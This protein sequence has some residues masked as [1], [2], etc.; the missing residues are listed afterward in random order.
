[1]LD[2]EEEPGESSRQKFY[3]KGWNS[4]ST[5]TFSLLNKATLLKQT[6]SV[7]QAKKGHRHRSPR[8]RRDAV[9]GRTSSWA[10]LY[11]LPSDT[12]FCLMQCRC[13]TAFPGDML[14]MRQVQSS[15]LDKTSDISLPAE[16]STDPLKSPASSSVKQC[17]LLLSNLSP[18]YSHNFLSEW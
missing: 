6:L 2:A 18:S 5:I 8:F 1:M 4:P 14:Q 16:V 11:V 10:H 17:H 7:P 12:L 3:N 13:G 9:L 15:L